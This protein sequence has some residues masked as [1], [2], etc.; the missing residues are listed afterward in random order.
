MIGS[1]IVADVRELLREHDRYWQALVDIAGL[2]N[3]EG[4]DPRQIARQALGQAV[5]DGIG[6]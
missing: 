2:E 1:E 6:R 3:W 5:A 4:R